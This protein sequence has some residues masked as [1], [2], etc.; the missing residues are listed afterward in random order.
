MSNLKC[1]VVFAVLVT[2][3]GIFPE[4]AKAQ[5]MGTKTWDRDPRLLQEVGDL[6]GICSS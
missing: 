6:F 1:A 3:S 4:T 5:A 2:M